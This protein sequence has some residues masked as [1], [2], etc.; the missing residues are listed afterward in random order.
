MTVIGNPLMAGTILWIVNSKRI[1]G[2]RRNRIKSN[3]LGLIGM[4][5]VILLAVR[6][7]WFLYLCL[8]LIV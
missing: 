6:M 5:V 1:M 2:E 3:L 7:L 4:T 8:S